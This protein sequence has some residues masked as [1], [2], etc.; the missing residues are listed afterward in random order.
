MF[1][2]EIRDN[3]CLHFPIM[4]QS[5]EFPSKFLQMSIFCQKK[6][7]PT[8]CIWHWR[9][10]Y[11][12]LGPSAQEVFVCAWKKK[13]TINAFGAYVFFKWTLENLG[14]N[15]HEQNKLQININ[16]ANFWLSKVC[17]L[18]K[19]VVEAQLINHFDWGSLS[20]V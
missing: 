1:V 2:W 18:C 8:K 10:C 19:L 3:E 15:G 11:N 17:C 16:W 6:Y 4:H 7:N 20:E 12:R 13:W 5:F 14:T 9:I